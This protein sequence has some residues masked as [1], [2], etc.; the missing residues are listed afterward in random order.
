MLIDV[1]AGG[2]GWFVDPTPGDDVEFAS[3]GASDSLIAT[4]ASPAS[5]RVDLLTVV[6][7]E[8]GHVLGLEDL[9]PNDPIDDLMAETLLPGVRRLPSSHDRP[10]IQSDGGTTGAAVADG[11]LPVSGPIPAPQGPPLGAA[12]PAAPAEFPGHDR[13]LR[14]LTQPAPG[15]IEADSVDL[16]SS[17]TMFVTPSAGWA[18]DSV[19]RSPSISNTRATAPRRPSLNVSIAAD[20]GRVSRVLYMGSELDRIDAAIAGLGRQWIDFTPDRGGTIGTAV[21]EY[22]ESL[23]REVSGISSLS[24]IRRMRRP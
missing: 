22:L 21:D 24:R 17:G 3:T 18:E 6:M 13:S 10:A 2:F 1:N 20:G 19:R 23:L 11:L 12:V 8:L 9:A 14:H 5:G 16:T 15:A 7:H 4:G